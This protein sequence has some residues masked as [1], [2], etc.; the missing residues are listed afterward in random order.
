VIAKDIRTNFLAASFAVTTNKPALCL[1]DNVTKKLI[2]I[3]KDAAWILKNGNKL[4]FSESMFEIY[5]QLLLQKGYRSLNVRKNLLLYEDI[6]A[7]Y[8]S[9]VL[10]I[11]N[12]N[13]KGVVP[14]S[15]QIMQKRN[16][17]ISPAC[18]LL[19]MRFLAGS[20]KEFFTKKLQLCEQMP[21]KKY[22]MYHRNKFIS[23]SIPKPMLRNHYREL[24]LQAMRENPNVSRS[25]LI[26]NYSAT[27]AWLRENDMDWYE[28]NSP[29][30]KLHMK[31]DRT[32]Y[33]EESL[34]KARVA[35]EYLKNFS[36]R[37]VWINLNSV[38]K[39]GGFNSL[40]NKLNNW[41]LP[42]TQAYLE[43]STET[44]DEWR[45]RKIRWTVKELYEAGRPL[46][47]PQIQIKAAISHACFV[48]LEGFVRDCIEQIQ[49]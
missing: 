17:L 4:P 31:Q 25:Y 32:A 18:H 28:E 16:S 39:Y 41:H 7:F 26:Q 47:L 2:N 37:P 20:A 42:K 30:S 10:N 27:Y 14:W 48:P 46:H 1:N 24:W 38:E 13:S 5:D 11:L 40:H 12:V 36:G 35:V 23:Q 21:S 22:N 34:E 19:V 29:D 33:D 9:E 15:T 49:K 6:S 44:A 3:A 45:K 43:Q 8:G